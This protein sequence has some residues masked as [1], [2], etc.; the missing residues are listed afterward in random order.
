MFRACLTR[1]FKRRNTISSL[2]SFVSVTKKRE[3]TF[4]SFE[5]SKKLNLCRQ[6]K[7]YMI[8]RDFT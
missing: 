2:S 6:N 8:S 5:P 1:G 4:A 7:F 3:K